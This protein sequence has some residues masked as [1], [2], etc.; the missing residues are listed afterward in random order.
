MNL[1]IDAICRN[2]ACLGLLILVGTAIL[3]RG[4]Y[5]GEYTIR[6]CNVPDQPPRSAVPWDW[7]PAH[8]YMFRHD[9]CASGG[10]F[11]L[12]A[13][14]MPIGTG[15]AVILRPPTD[16][17]AIRRVKLWMTARL[18]GTGSSLHVLTSSGGVA[19][20][21]AHEN[22]FGPPGGETLS[23]P[24]TS[25]ELA[26]DTT[27]YHVIV[28]CSADAGVGCSPSSATPLDIRGAE[29]VLSEN[30]LPAVSL[31]GGS[32]LATDGPRRSVETVTYAAT[33][34]ESGV[35]KVSALLG[36]TIV[37]TRASSCAY[38]D[39][40]ACPTEQ[41]DSIAV[42][43]NAVPDGIYPLTVEVQDAAGNRRA[44]VAERGVAVSNVPSGKAVGPGPSLPQQSRLSV[45]FTRHRG[46]TINVRYGQSILVSG[47]LETEDRAVPSA[48]ITAWQRGAGRSRWRGVGSVRTRR[49]G[50]FSFR[51]RIWG[52]TRQLELR[53]V[54]RGG[55]VTRARRL[56][57]R[58]AAVGTLGVSLQRV[59]VR[60]RGRVR[61]GPFPLNG[62]LIFMEGRA[63]G[64]RW[65]RFARLRTDG[66]GRFTGRY[67]LRVYRPGVRLQFRARIP[68]ERGYHYLSA[69]S[70]TVTRHV[71]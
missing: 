62:K 7:M 45:R 41:R 55:S 58:V 70:G 59:D 5:A 40:A 17:I 67:R 46:S 39:F 2:A 44:V 1:V 37:G 71:R 32:I 3:P 33:D 61:G 48:R 22:I 34:G 28:G 11:G 38:S 65:T 12:N 63:L 57:V 54:G 18:G 9:E 29:V 56:R 25:A 47:L 30:T 66:I 60:Y 23:A 50:T 19:S 35:S 6:S 8:P 49:D 68:M 20:G 27:I 26:D 69:V 15:A 42:D 52:A 31:E 43:T 36:N 21:E 64:G 53:Y 14:P 16:K 24:W 10:G 13:G 4:A 51:R